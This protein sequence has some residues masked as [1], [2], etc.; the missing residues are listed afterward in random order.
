VVNQFDI[1]QLDG[2]FLDEWSQTGAPKIIFNYRDPRDTV[3]SMVNFLSD[4]TGKGFSDYHDLPVFSRILKSK[5]TLEEQL[6]YA[7]TDPAFPGRRDLGHMVWLLDHPD[8]CKTS[9]EELV[10]PRGGGSAQA[11]A[12]ALDRIFEF[13][14]VSGARS[15][16][17]AGSLFN[18]DV[19]TFYRGQI[20]S[21]REA[22]TPELRR[23]ADV[24]LGDLLDLYGYERGA[25]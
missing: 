24:S 1:R 18:P 15:A 12:R 17:V 25:L 2:H 9:F 22:F 14:G 7:L 6:A 21:W 19:F 10:G 23:L 11:Q 20:G 13:L 8:V 3:L 5:A 4:R 16:E